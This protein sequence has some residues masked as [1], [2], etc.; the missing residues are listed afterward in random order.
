MKKL[1]LVLAIACLFVQA[2]AQKLAPKEVPEAVAAAFKQGNPNVKIVAWN[3]AGG[4][5]M[6]MFKSEKMEV[7]A[8]Y[9]VEG[10]LMN[11]LTQVAVADLPPTVMEY[12][13]T[14]YPKSKVEK[15]LKMTNALSV[16]TSY[17]LKTSEMLLLFKPDGS[18]SKE[19]KY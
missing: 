7:V 15:A 12:F 19:V 3:K 17:Q 4:S 14:T 2:Q 9:D 13:K 10:K 1:I 16:I 11:T 8:T 6:A 5:Y 18:F